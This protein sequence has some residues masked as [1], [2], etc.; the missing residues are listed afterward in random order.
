M[1]TGT[2]GSN[3]AKAARLL[4]AGFIGLVLGLTLAPGAAQA[5]AGTAACKRDLFVLDSTL[6]NALRDLEA[7]ARANDDAKCTAYRKHVDVMRQASKTF[8][9][10]TTGRERQENV[11]Q[12]DSSVADFEVL[13][14]TRCAKP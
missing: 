14:R 8:A 12:M 4:R 11:A 3:R 5:Q 10:C 2:S 7:V 6:R 1:P 13:I 9:R